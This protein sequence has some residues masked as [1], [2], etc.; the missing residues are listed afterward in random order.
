M[1]YRIQAPEAA[2]LEEKIRLAKA[3][4]SVYMGYM[5]GDGFIA[6]TR[7]VRDL[8]DRGEG[9]EERRMRRMLTPSAGW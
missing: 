6:A 9:A 5:I 1:S 7:A 4:R 2:T 3:E 8:L